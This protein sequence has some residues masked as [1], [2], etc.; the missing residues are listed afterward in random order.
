MGAKWR[1]SQ[2]KA[3]LEA[4]QQHGNNWDL[5]AEEVWRKSSSRRSAPACAARCQSE[6]D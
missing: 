3:L 6:E 1:V 4:V 2:E 5:I